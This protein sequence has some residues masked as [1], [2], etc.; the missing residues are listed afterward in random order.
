MAKVK[1][2]NISG[3]EVSELELPDDIFANDKYDHLLHEVVRYSQANRRGGNSAVKTRS[4]VRGG[5]KK[6]YKQKGT[7]RARHGG[8]RAPQMRGGGVAHGPQVRS[9]AFKLNKKVRAAALKGA[10]SRRGQTAKVVVFDSLELETIKTKPVVALLAK[11]SIDSALFVLPENDKN[12]SLSARN[13]PHIKVLTEQGLNVEDVLRHTHLCLTTA[14]VD[15][16]RER[17]EG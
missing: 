16:L 8:S 17:I 14:T 2:L 5:G 4:Q 12:F 11:L 3:K 7:G 15:K 6:M 9:Y 10:L 1:V 13:I